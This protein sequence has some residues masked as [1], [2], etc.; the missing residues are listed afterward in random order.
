MSNHKLPT[1]AELHSD[2]PDAYANDQ[3]KTLLNAPPPAA[4]VK[5]HPMTNL[6]YLP[7]DKVDFLLDRIFGLWNLEIKS[8]QLIANSVV[9]VV[10][11]GVFN[12]VTKEWLYMD[13]TGA[14]P[15]Q[16][17]SQNP[18]S[19]LSKIKSNAVQLAAPAS[20][21][22][23]KKDAV[24]N[25]G[26]IFG[27]DVTRKDTLV[28]DPTFKEDPYVNQPTEGEKTPPPPPPLPGNIAEKVK[29]E[30][31]QADAPPVLPANA[32]AAP[33]TQPATVQLPNLDDTKIDF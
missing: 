31:K 25:F 7:V 17:D 20:V 12:P 3:L 6:P 28:F 33:V 10:R 27:R 16:V 21:S 9:S 15:L 32:F 24:E 26:K 23:A 30:Q 14:M 4:W 29:P 2:N 22:Y 5:K 11:V 19:D 18:A 8:I 1:L 13:G